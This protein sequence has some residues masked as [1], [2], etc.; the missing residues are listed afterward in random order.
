MKHNNDG[1]PDEEQRGA[2]RST[3]Q[4]SGWNGIGLLSDTYC[5][6]Y[7]HHKILVEERHRERNQT[8]TGLGLRL[9]FKTG[10]VVGPAAAVTTCSILRGDTPPT[11]SVNARQTGA[12]TL[13]S[14]RALSQHWMRGRAV[15]HK[16]H[17]C[18]VLWYKSD[19]N[20]SVVR[21]HR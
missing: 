9:A 11:I 4:L 20:G 12:G 8:E 13:N 19:T 10:N 14:P 1:R 15:G 21:L 7:R 3:P 18:L 5:V 17:S 16:L 6:S 2:L